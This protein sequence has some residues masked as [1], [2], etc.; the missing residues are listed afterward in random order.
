M[1][2]AV[3]L[4]AALFLL[5]ALASAQE[6]NVAIGLG[7]RPAP[8][9]IFDQI[10]D[11]RER[12]AFRELWDAA[13][14]SQMDLAVRF[15]DQYPRSIVLREAYELAARAFVEQ[16]DLA[17]GL[18]WASRALRLMPE[19]PSL[20]VMVGDIAAKARRPRSGGRERARCAPISRARRTTVIAFAAAVDGTAR[21][22]AGNRSLRAGTRRSRPRTVQGSGTV[23]ARLADAES[24]RHRSALHHRRRSNGRS[25]R[26]RCGA[27][28][29][30]R[31]ADRWR[32]GHGCTRRAACTARAQRRRPA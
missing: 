2:R 19:N 25:S 5:V 12:R 3:Y 7:G 18:T 26:R 14:R 17:Q 1:S 22:D 9:T 24:R 4:L 8:V 11:A 27:R 28:L 10:E 6:F 30:A 29:L 20:L 31:G 23:A 13:P 32:N 21:R 16:G 15:V